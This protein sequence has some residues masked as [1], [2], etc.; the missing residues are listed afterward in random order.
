[1]KKNLLLS[2]CAVL[3]LSLTFTACAQQ[4]V[5]GS[6]NYV[7]KNVK[8]SNFEGIK[9]SGSS[10]IIYTQK[11]GTPS[12]EIYGSD[13]LI[14]LLETFVENGNLIIKYKKNTS[15]R[16]GKMQIKVSA[17]A[18]SSLSISGSGDVKLAN[19]ITTNKDVA[20][21]ISGSGDIEGNKVS[22]RNLAV[23]V[24]GSGDIDLKGVAANH[25]EV[26]IS[27]SG[28]ID[29]AGNC[30]DAAYKISGSGDING[31]NLK[32]NSVNARISGSG[33]IKCYATETLQGGV[34]GSGAVG[35]KGNPRIEFSKKGLY[36]L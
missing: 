33:S 16:N 36:R 7:T 18:I 21:S 26:T 2:T 30:A 10:N 31:A 11:E 28:D 5:T 12:I 14:P 29:I 6:K 27:G 24:S 22:C 34:S 1:M 17:P 23:K 19:G 13:N 25:T 35:Y 8:V 9:L 20:I 3:L 32:A 4:R 15:I